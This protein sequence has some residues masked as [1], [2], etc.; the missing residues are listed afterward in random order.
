[1]EGAEGSNYSHPYYKESLD[2][3]KMRERRR[4]DA[5]IMHAVRRRRH[6]YDQKTN[7]PRPAAYV[8]QNMHLTH[9]LSH[10]YFLDPR[11]GITRL[12]TYLLK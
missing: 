4:R 11:I 3:H 9:L 5:C 6:L 12:C 8:S 10:I 2:P 1:M 7:K